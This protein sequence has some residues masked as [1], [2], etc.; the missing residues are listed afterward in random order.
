MKLTSI[1]EAVNALDDDKIA[2]RLG[3]QIAA[4]GKSLICP[5][6]GHG[7]HGDGLRFR[8]SRWECYGGCRRSYSNAALIAAVERITDK[9]EL[10]RHLER[11]FPEE[12][13]NHSS[14]QRN[15]SAKGKETPE[16]VAT[17]RNF[18]SLYARCRAHYP[19]EKFVEE[20]GGTWRGLTNETLNA[21][22]AVY[23]AEYIYDK[24]KPPVPAI[25]LPYDDGLYYWRRVDKVPEGE[26]KGGV[27]KGVARKPY[28]KALKEPLDARFVYFIV[29]GE[30][31]SLSI[32][33]VWGNLNGVIA[34][35]SAGAWQMLVAELERRF[36]KTL[37][38]PSFVVLF[39]NDEA[40][41]K[42]A[43]LLRR[44]LIAAGFPAVSEYLQ[45]F[46]GAFPKVDANNLLQAGTD[47]LEKSLIDA[48]DDAKRYLWQ[49]Q[50][51]LEAQGKWR[52]RLKYEELQRQNISGTAI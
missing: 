5:I 13:G 41:F 23:H 12:K 28:F 21:A 1:F 35:G 46:A 4:D 34:T 52:D 20:C 11:M 16:A 31:D 2:D 18:A 49:V 47:K 14:F 3:L 50:D 19:L 42:N 45:E 51:E 9:A 7:T 15:Q 26:R 24:S 6:C 29:E 27:P 40:G 48:Y 39:D 25:I 43:P 36:A 22:G 32:A 10:A 37:F 17:P 8:K 30:L 38:K 33:Q 44:A